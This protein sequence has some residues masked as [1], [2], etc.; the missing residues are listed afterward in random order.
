MNKVKPYLSFVLMFL[1]LAI[2]GKAQSIVMDLPATTYD[3]IRMIGPDMFQVTGKKGKTGV[4]S[5]DGTIIVPVEC[6]LITPFYKGW[7]LLLSKDLVI[8][9]ISAEGQYNHFDKKYYPIDRQLFFS[10]GLLTVVNARNQFAYINTSGKEV[11]VMPEEYSMITPFTEGYAVAFTEENE[12]SNLMDKAGNI[13]TPVAGDGVTLIRTE[14]VYEGIAYMWDKGGNYYK[15][16]VIDRSIE[17]TSKREGSPDYLYRRTD[18]GS[19]L[20]YDID[21]QGTITKGIELVEA[22]GLI[23]YKDTQTDSILLP[24]QLLEAG[25]FIDNL[26]IVKLETG[27]CGILRYD[28][29]ETVGFS[30]EPNGAPTLQGDWATCGFSVTMPDSWFS[31]D[32]DVEV[33]RDGK[34]IDV[35]DNG[36]G[37]FSFKYR[38][39]GSSKEDFDICLKSQ[40]LMWYTAS[41]S[42][43]FPRDVSAAS[44]QS[45][46]KVTSEKNKSGEDK[47]VQKKNQEKKPKEEKKKEK[48]EKEKKKEEKKKEETKE[49]KSITQNRRH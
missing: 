18:K 5:S 38:K 22:N 11:L 13:I 12:K 34:P 14:G 1:L 25:P 8:G 19:Q 30:V 15:Y 48:K 29:N 28:S 23:G 47:A 17:P 31:S 3:E 43:T 40:D 46:S 44:S 6:D 21:Y 36:N 26:A 45:E 49:N 32:V 2:D 35:T 16:N 42:Y 24:C 33:S 39:K 10:E 7:A 41:L 9:C 37:N 4:I 27:K 20:P